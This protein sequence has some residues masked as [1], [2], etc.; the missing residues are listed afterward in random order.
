MSGMTFLLKYTGLFFLFKQEGKNVS[1]YSVLRICWQKIMRN[2]KNNATL[3]KVQPQF[4]P[5]LSENDG[6]NI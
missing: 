3:K 6:K 5:G 2:D 1:E 4:S